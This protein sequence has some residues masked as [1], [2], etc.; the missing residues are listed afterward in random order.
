MAHIS[1]KR[2]YFVLVTTKYLEGYFFLFYVTTEAIS[3]V[4]S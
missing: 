2:S 1:D 4:P 3:M